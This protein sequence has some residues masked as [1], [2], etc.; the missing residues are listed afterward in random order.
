MKAALCRIEHKDPDR[1]VD[2]TQHR[3]HRKIRA[4]VEVVVVAA[5]LH[6]AF[7]IVH[8]R[9]EPLFGIAG[10]QHHMQALADQGGGRTGLRIQRQTKACVVCRSAERQSACHRNPQ[11]AG[12]A[13]GRQMQEAKAHAQLARTCAQTLAR[14]LRT[15]CP[16]MHEDAR[17]TPIDAGERG[18]RQL[19]GPVGAQAGQRTQ[20]DTSTGCRDHSTDWCPVACFQASRIASM[21][22]RRCGVSS[23]RIT[24]TLVPS[25]FGSFAPR[26]NH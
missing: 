3:R 14:R 24:S 2:L 22:L 20:N 26:N 1:L 23:C 9:V 4:P 10:R 18:G 5:Q 8:I 21:S 13:D 7:A 6:A 12:G 19:H 25:R 11:C 15:R 17:H 16:P